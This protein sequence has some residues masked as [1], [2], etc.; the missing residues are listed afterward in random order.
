MLFPSL[1][2]KQ[3]SGWPVSPLLEHLRMGMQWFPP[4]ATKEG[5]S[6]KSGKI[7]VGLKLLNTVLGF[8]VIRAI[9]PYAEGRETPG[10]GNYKATAALPVEVIAW[11]L[12][13]MYL[14][15]KLFSVEQYISDSWKQAVSKRTSQSPDGW[16]HT[17]ATA[18]ITN[19]TGVGHKDKRRS[20]DKRPARKQPQAQMLLLEQAGEENENSKLGIWAV[21]MPRTPVRG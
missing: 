10:K 9:P 7:L 8:W 2:E 15:T 4:P 5:L 17:S 12:W 11:I 14:H 16:F 13:R 3:Q 19:S 6:P 18:V 1:R 21:T 20:L